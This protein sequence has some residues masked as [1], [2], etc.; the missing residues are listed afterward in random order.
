MDAT[1]TKVLQHISNSRNAYGAYARHGGRQGVGHVSRSLEKGY[2]KSPPALSAVTTEANE[3]VTRS[4][5]AR[6]AQSNTTS[7]TREKTPAPANLPSSKYIGQALYPT[8]ARTS[9]KGIDGLTDGVDGLGLH[10]NAAEGDV[11]NKAV[12]VAVNPRFGHVAI[13]TE[14]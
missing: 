9:R 5:S 4:I 10:K 8:K 14:K 11:A 7:P 1:D 12:N 13:G 6:S 3:Q 2:R